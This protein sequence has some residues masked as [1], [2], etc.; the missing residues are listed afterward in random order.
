MKV[1]DL[2]IC[3]CISDVWYRGLVGV[4]IGFDYHG[5]YTTDK[6]DPLVMYPEQIMRLTRTNLETVSK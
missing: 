3:N 5:M 4:L 6:G 1:G 2:V